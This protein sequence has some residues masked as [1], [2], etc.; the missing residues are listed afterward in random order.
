MTILLMSTISVFGQNHFA[1]LKTGVNLTNVH[2]S[3]FI[4]ND[5]NRTG[6][7]GGL[8][9]E[10]LLNKRFNLG[11]DFLYCQKGFTSDMIFTDETNNPTGEKATF[12]YNYNYLSFPVKGGFLI[13]EKISGFVNFGIV[14]SFLIN[15][16]HISPA[17]GNIIDEDI[18]NV[19]SDVKKLDFGGLV[20]IG[21]NY[22]IKDRYLIY[23]SV[24]YQQ[25][26]TTITNSD[27][28]P[29][30]EVKNYGITLSIGL[31]YAIKNE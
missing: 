20:E 24:A 23:T 16:S 12:V 2:S 26:F 6:F 30:S 4:S 19:T 25:S 14:P 27:Y 10:Y 31:K 18:I 11:V 28:W 9:Y 29:D 22:K 3:D 17:I 13:G 8:T 15:A 21:G 7:S 1:G 5:G